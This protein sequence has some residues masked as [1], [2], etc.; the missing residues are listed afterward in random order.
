MIYKEAEKSGNSWRLFNA[1]G[2]FLKQKDTMFVCLCWESA[3]I[4]SIQSVCNKD[5]ELVGQ[6]SAQFQ[7]RG[8]FGKGVSGDQS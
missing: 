2:Y 3:I 5:L 7:V 8:L 4:S 1:R 6:C